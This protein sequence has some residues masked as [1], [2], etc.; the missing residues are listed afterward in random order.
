MQVN[1]YHC[2]NLYILQLYKLTHT[3]NQSNYN[4]FTNSYSSSNKPF[5]NTICI[6]T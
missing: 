1:K 6:E 2:T 3:H 4:K 5:D